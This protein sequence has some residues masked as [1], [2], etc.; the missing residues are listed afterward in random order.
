MIG[1]M[2]VCARRAAA[3]IVLSIA[4]G[5]TARADENDEEKAERLFVE[6]REL[7]VQGRVAEACA[8]LEES[9]RLSPAGGA[10]LNLAECYER[11]GRITSA[12]ERFREAKTRAEQTGRKDAEQIATERA[13][14]LE[15]RLP[16]IVVVI[17]TPYEAIVVRRDGEPLTKS[18]WGTAVPVDP[19]LHEIVAEV[20]GRVPFRWSGNVGE[21]ARVEVRIP[22][23]LPMVIRNDVRAQSP[24]RWRE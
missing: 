19:G 16:R 10:M 12:W 7:L 14:R 8:R 3:L 2:R 13:L 21:G 17:E 23:L 15:P 6:G 18:V 1:I 9:L 22:A 24:L 5:T 11:A 20:P 4:F